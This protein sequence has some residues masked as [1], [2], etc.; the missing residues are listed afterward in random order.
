MTY[1]AIL[2]FA[3]AG[4]L[5]MLNSKKS[6]RLAVAFLAL[7]LGVE[8]YGVVNVETRE[9]KGYS[10]EIVMDIRAFSEDGEPAVLKDGGLQEYDFS[11][12]STE[13]NPIYIVDEWTDYPWGSTYP[14]RDYRAT[15][16]EKLSD[17]KADKFWVIASKDAKASEVLDPEKYDILITIRN[18][19][20][21]AIEYKVK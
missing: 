2:V 18:D 7:T 3:L 6:R 14:L 19:H 17:L 8:I 4:V 11:F 20:H 12:Y 13:K 16:I 9:P 15:T 21:L 1:S 5:V 10:K